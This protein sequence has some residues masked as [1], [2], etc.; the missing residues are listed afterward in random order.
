MTPTQ[1]R[2]SINTGY[3][4]SLSSVAALSGLLF[5]FD[6]AVINGAIVFL[7]QE[8]RL[9]DG[10]TEWAAS[11]LLVGCLAGSAAAGSV[12]DRYGRRRSLIG[13]ALLFCV[14]S[15]WTAL[16][17]SLA[18]FA[19]ARLTAGLAIGIASVLAPMYIAEISPAAIRGKLVTL[20]QMAIVTGILLSYFV[21]WQL[22]A[23]GQSSWRWMFASAAVPSIAFLIAL[24][25][26]PESPRWLVRQGRESES[27]AILGR[28]GGLAS[29]DEQI[30]EIRASLAEETGS[31]TEILQPRLRRPM[32]IAILLAVLSQVT[33]INT[34]IYYGSVIFKEH[35]GRAAGDALGA[36]VIIGVI[37][38]LCTIVAILFIDR[39]G[40]KPLLLAGS[41]G[42]GA[43]L[44]LVAVAFR[45]T[46]LPAN[47]V[48]GAVLAYVACFAISLGPGSW[49]YISELFPTAVR[50]RAMSIATL[51]L[52]AACTLVTFTFL[53]M[54]RLLGP[55]GAFLVYA[56]FCAV[57]FVFVWR[58]TPETKGR[59]LEEIS[60]SWSAS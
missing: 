23:I 34:V 45:A 48:L 8:F 58:F 5:G 24:L 53:T 14:S 16:P 46:P 50:G 54:L 3:V 35:A 31:F 1:V 22:S 60:S 33:G 28:V 39:L 19:T 42:M 13:A 6:T 56:M 4:Y 52:W 51:A 37:N 2:Q 29:A 9:T 11:A 30:A 10:Q 26:I 27:R 57:A 41:A 17:S 15:L 55:S 7:R 21:N 49:V 36:N 40:R 18:G 25:F 43:A 20:N 32:M 44:V 47:L 12:A 38:F 59:T